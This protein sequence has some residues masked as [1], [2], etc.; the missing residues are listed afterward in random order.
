M[1]FFKTSLL[2]GA[3]ALMTSPVAAQYGREEEAA[4]KASDQGSGII[5]AAKSYVELLKAVFLGGIQAPTN[6]LV[7]DPTGIITNF[8]DIDYQDSLFNDEWIVA[9]L[10]ST[11][12]P[13]ADYFPTFWDAAVTMDK[14]TN[15]KFATVWVEEAPRVAARFFV[16]TRLPYVLYAKDGEFRHIPYERNNTQFIV[17]FIEEEKYQYYPVL[18]GPMSPYSYLALLMVKYADLMEWVGERT[19]WMPKWLGYIIAGSLSGAVFQFFSGGSQY[20]SD[21]SKYPHLN[22]D[23]TL[24]KDSTAASITNSTSTSTKTSK[25][26]STKKRSTKK[27]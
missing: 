15:T 17:D 18:S 9:F 6:H 25:T 16:P 2:I 14:E 4:A 7:N 8:T 21:P 11:S 22:A 24:K 19:A 13:S 5:G 23:G 20:A 27:A 10:S 26:S 3:I 1:K 12:A